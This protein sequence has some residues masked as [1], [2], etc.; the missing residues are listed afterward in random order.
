MKSTRPLIG[1]FV[2]LALGMN[3]VAA[4]RA[5]NECCNSSRLLPRGQMRIGIECSMQKASEPSYGCGGG[6]IVGDARKRV[7]GLSELVAQMMT[8][9]VKPAAAMRKVSA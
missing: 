1:L 2:L 8:S 6:L 9:P 7:R 5:D 4:L 3:P